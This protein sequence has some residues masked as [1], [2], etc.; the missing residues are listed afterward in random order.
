MVSST[1]PRLDDRWPPVWATDS[2]RNVRNSAASAGIWLRSS[3]RRSAGDW[4]VSSRGEETMSELAVTD[5]IGQLGQAGC[6]RSE[7]GQGGAAL[8]I[9]AV[10]E[11]AGLVKSE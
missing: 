10:G 5:E 6:T 7:G 9:Q 1:V 4:M 2:T 8:G 11:G 3:W